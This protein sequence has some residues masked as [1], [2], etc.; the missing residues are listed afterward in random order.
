MIIGYT[1]NIVF[2]ITTK[3]FFKKKDNKDKYNKIQSHFFFEYFRINNIFC[4]I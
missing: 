3:K 4:S 1:P 2:I